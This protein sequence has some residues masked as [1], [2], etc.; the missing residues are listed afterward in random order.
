MVVEKVSYDSISS[1]IVA[2]NGPSA[3][4]V[5][6]FVSYGVIFSTTVPTIDFLQ[7]G[8]GGI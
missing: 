1:T 5:V 8:E 2:A 4:I 6:E 7:R 3:R